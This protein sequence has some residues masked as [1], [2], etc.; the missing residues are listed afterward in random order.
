MDLGWLGSGWLVRATNYLG[1]SV[2]CIGWLLTGQGHVKVSMK[3]QVCEK[4][5]DHRDGSSWGLDG[6]VVNLLGPNSGQG[7]DMYAMAESLASGLYPR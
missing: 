3:L 4:A 6:F 7:P 1:T 2:P 5:G